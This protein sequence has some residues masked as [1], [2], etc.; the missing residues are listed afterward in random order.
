M[1]LDGHYYS[2]DLVSKKSFLQDKPTVFFPTI[3]TR[4]TAIGSG[5]KFKQLT[6]HLSPRNLSGP[7]AWRDASWLW[8]ATECS[9]R[10]GSR[11]PLPSAYIHKL[12]ALRAQPRPPGCA[13]GWQRHHADRRGGGRASGEPCGTRWF[14]PYSSKR[15]RAPE[16][17]ERTLPPVYTERP[18]AA[19][20]RVQELPG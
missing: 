6:S 5:E 17:E 2:L 20:L 11:H 13:G 19:A 10:H 8:R 16:E 1:P 3:T 15:S 9:V 7:V 14:C 18:E 4:V 12:S